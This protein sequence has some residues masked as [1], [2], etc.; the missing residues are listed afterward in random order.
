MTNIIIV[1]DHNLIRLGIKSSLKAKH[2]DICIV[3]EAGDGKSLFQLLET[4][5]ADIVLLDISLPDMSGMDI[6]SRLR[7]EYPYIKI[8]IVSVEN[9]LSIIEDLLRIGIDG[10][11]SKQQAT[12]EELSQ[13]I[14][15]IMDGLEYF[16]RDIT[17]ILYKIYISKKKITTAKL[18]FS[19]RELDIITLCREGLQS[20]EIAKHL[21]ISP[22]TVDTHKNNIFKKLGI[23]STLEMVLYAMEN[24]IIND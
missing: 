12:G 1:D 24:G 23:N 17:S 7:N 21:N 20:K 3:G 8:L 22:R 13:A 11:I 6:A 10:F 9:T 15:S 2:S 4:T 5:Q 16:G 18:E 14:H 19:E